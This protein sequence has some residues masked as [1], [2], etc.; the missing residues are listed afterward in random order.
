MRPSASPAIE[1]DA[2]VERFLQVGHQIGEH[3]EQAGHVEA[4]DDHRHAGRTKRPRDIERARILI[5]LHADQPDKA[6]LAVRL[7]LAR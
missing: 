4:A 1:R 2:H 7:H 5:G 6:E 3:G